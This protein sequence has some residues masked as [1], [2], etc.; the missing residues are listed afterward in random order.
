MRNFTVARSRRRLSFEVPR[1]WCRSRTGTK[2]DTERRCAYAVAKLSHDTLVRG[3]TVDFGKVWRDQ[4]VGPHLRDALALAATHS[5]DVIIDPP[6]TMRNVTEWVSSRHVGIG[7][8]S[9]RFLGLA[10]GWPS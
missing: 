9:C 8:Q 7:C 2:A 10:I 3:R 5:H 1:H 4:S 6:G